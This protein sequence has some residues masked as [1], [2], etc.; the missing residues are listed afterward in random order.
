MPFASGPAPGRLAW[1]P[2]GLHLDG[3]ADCGDGLFVS[4]SAERRL[5]IM[6][7]PRL[8]AFGALALFFAL[9]LKAAA[10]YAIP[11]KRCRSRW[12]WCSAAG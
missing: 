3:V 6:Q 4:A 8:G 1:L 5:E 11:Q 10:L 7:D 12:P 9:L 2:G